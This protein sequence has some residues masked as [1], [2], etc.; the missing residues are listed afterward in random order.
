[1]EE[2]RMKKAA[3]MDDAYK[4]L[5]RRLCAELRY[6]KENPDIYDIK[7]ILRDFPLA[8]VHPCLPQPRN[9]LC[10]CP[11]TQAERDEIDAL[12][13]GYASIWVLPPN[14]AHYRKGLSKRNDFPRYAYVQSGVTWDRIK[15]PERGGSPLIYASGTG[16]K[17]V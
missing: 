2:R 14:N 8:N 11:M 15:E 12:L 13:N 5:R 17:L 3:A 6:Y 1:M 9:E 16:P 10:V 7:T 4:E